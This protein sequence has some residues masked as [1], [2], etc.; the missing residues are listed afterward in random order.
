MIS[1]QVTDRASKLLLDAGEYIQP[2]RLGEGEV[3]AD[4]PARLAGGSTRGSTQLAT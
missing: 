2:M 4:L 3:P 1:S